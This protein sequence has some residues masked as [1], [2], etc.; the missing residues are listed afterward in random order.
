MIASLIVITYNQVDCLKEL[1]DSINS[2]F[3]EDNFQTVIVNDCSTDETGVYLSSLPPGE[4]FV[5]INSERNLGRAGARNLG[6][7]NASGDILIFVDGD[8]KL[9]DRF[10]ANHIEFH[11][12]NKETT[13]GVGRVVYRHQDAFSRYLQSCGAARNPDSESVPFRY[14]VSWNIS[15]PRHIF[16]RLNGFDDSF[17]TEHHNVGEDL[18]FGY[19][20]HQAG[21]RISYLPSALAEHITKPSLEIMLEKRYKLGLEGL[22]LF[23]KKHPQATTEIPVCKLASSSVLLRFML[24]IALHPFIYNPLRKLAKSGIGLPGIAYEYLLHGAVLKGLWENDKLT[25]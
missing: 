1:M 21:C 14:F 17:L 18:E 19:R 8:L 10:V 12:Q 25:G 7:T 20:L 22:P 2:Q 5:V 23:I 4:N 6:A 15:V 3:T 9:S 13:A 16:E 11:R 24:R